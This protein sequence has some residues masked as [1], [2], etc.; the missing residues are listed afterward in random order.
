MKNIFHENRIALL[1]FIAETKNTCENFSIPFG[2][3]IFNCHIHFRF[4]LTQPS[5][6]TAAI[7]SRIVKF[8][9][10]RVRFSLVAADGYAF[11]IDR[12]ISDGVYVAAYPLHDVSFLYNYLEGLEF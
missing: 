12:L 8:I 1:L 2:T 5:F 6:F 3:N 11:G 10:D 4:D 9:L 7:R